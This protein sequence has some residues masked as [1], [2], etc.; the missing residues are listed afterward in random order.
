[1]EFGSAVDSCCASAGPAL[2]TAG[3]DLEIGERA[4]RSHLN[5]IG[6]ATW[7]NKDCPE[8]DFSAALF[9]PCTNRDAQVLQTVQRDDPAG[10]ACGRARPFRADCQWP[11]WAS[12][13]FGP[14]FPHGIRLGW[15]G[16]QS[17]ERS[18]PLCVAVLRS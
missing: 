15:F 7:P 12:V 2:N 6:A 1:M 8:G 4:V 14:P 18:P 3:Y 10:S 5:S 17:G 16:A 13:C 11:G 9:S